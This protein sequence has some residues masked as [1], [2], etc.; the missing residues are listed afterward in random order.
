[1]KVRD[2]LKRMEAAGWRQVSQAGSHRQY[3]HPVHKGR[4]TVAGHPNDDVSIGT[5]KS[6][7]R[8]AQLKENE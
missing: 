3:K 1:M 6:I 2:I 5:L 4:V 7:Y 8:Q